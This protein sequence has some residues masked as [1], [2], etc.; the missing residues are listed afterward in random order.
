MYNYVILYIYLY[1]NDSLSWD[2]STALC[3]CV[4]VVPSSRSF[5]GS[6][7]SRRKRGMI[8]SVTEKGK[9]TSFVGSPVVVVPCS[10]R[11][12]VTRDEPSPKA[13]EKLRRRS[14]LSFPTFR[15][16]KSRFKNQFSRS[17][18]RVDTRFN[19]RFGDVNA[20]PS[21]LP[22]DSTQVGETDLANPMYRGRRQSVIDKNR[23]FA[24][25]RSV[26]AFISFLFP[27]FF[28]A[29]SLFLLL[30]LRANP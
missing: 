18:T 3:T 29:F 12:G 24:S 8:K 14:N 7:R 21:C 27:L 4:Y 2:R 22:V 13:D 16:F 6:P 25:T 30:P 10:T 5:L 28:L 17:S 11:S 15:V 1:T 20:F 26:P 9:T 23:S 19:K